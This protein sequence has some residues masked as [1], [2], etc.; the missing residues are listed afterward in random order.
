MEENNQHTKNNTDGFNI[1]EYRCKVKYFDVSTGKNIVVLN[2]ERAMEEDIYVSDRVVVQSGEK[3]LTC[4]VDLSSVLVKRDEIAMFHESA[5][6]LGVKADQ[7]VIISHA[8]HPISVDYI[9]KKM[10]GE[11]LSEEEI[12]TIITEAMD[13]RLSDVELASLLTTMYIRELSLNETV[14]LTN[15]VVATG[16]QLV[17]GKHPVLDKHCSG[18]VAGNRTTM[19][20][21]PIIAAAGLYIPKTS[22][23][24]I[25]SASG[26]ADTMEAIAEVKF[27]ID[28]MKEIVLRH[29]GCI[30]WGGAIN[31]ATIDDKL[32]KI[33]H[34]LRLDPKGVL[35]ASILAKKKSVG[36]E[37]VVIDIPVGRGSKIE[38]V[39]DAKA[40][41]KDFINVGSKLGMKIECF[42]SDG[43]DPV[44]MGIGPALECADVFDVLR[45]K[46]PL[47]LKDKS[48][49]LAG[50][51]LELCKKVPKGRGAAVASDILSSGKAYEKMKD[52]VE[53]QGGDRN[54][55]RDN[56]QIGTNIH[57]VCAKKDGRVQ[58]VDN[59]LISKIARAAGA[60]KDIGAGVI[61]HCEHG[62]KVKEGDVLFEI[63]SENESKLDFAIKSLETWYPIELERLIIGKL[64][65]DGYVSKY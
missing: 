45:N 38:N 59:L 23:R 31:L 53:A 27:S 19:L 52:I 42:I 58:H 14:A 16:E 2:K 41:G 7:E 37:Y 32:I 57:K 26:T 3:K 44:G 11:E 62:D 17:L 34:P 55:S 1:R 63:V 61:L 10:N 6:K 4:V 43:S 21:V 9:K 5:A 22:S 24:S 65:G 51:L 54:L 35:L 29:K 60:P 13:N 8:R 40:L 36:A 49:Q 18:G 64:V 39:E 46:G 30:V 33:R 56:L 47:D 12:N 20:V 50:E 28:E 15:A 25:T 48:I